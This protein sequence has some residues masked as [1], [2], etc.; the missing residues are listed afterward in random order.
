MKVLTLAPLAALL[1]ALS[2]PAAAQ[3]YVGRVCLNSTVTERES[4]PVTGQTF[5]VQYEATN[6]GGT[7]Y[8]IAGRV[9]TPDQPFIVTGMGTLVGAVLY[10]NTTGT[11]SHSDGWRDTGVTQTRLDLA[12]MTGT[13]YEIGRDFS[14]STRQFD[15]RY[16]AGTVAATSCP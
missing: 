14:R 9:E 4:G 5:L 8:A 10:I 12:T 13:F 11:Q 16:T 2:A 3:T 7:F 1:L 6:L 15:L